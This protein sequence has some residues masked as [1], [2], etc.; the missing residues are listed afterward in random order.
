MK[1]YDYVYWL[2]DPRQ[3]RLHFGLTDFEQRRLHF[4][5]QRRSLGVLTA[6][7]NGRWGEVEPA[8]GQQRGSL[9]R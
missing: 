8:S 2:V 9:A 4:G 5:D 6:I 1:R 7:A 3:L